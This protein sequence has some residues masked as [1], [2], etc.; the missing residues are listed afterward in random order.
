LNKIAVIALGSN[1]GD[2]HAHLTYAVERLAELL[3]GVRVSST[4]ESAPAAPATLQDPHYLNA[5]AIGTTS[6]S[7]R[8]LLASLLEIERL[9][10]RSRPYPGAPRTLDLDLVLLGD[11]IVKEPG[12]EVPHPRFR[13]R[14]FV[15]EPLVELAPD[16][17]DPMTGLTIRALLE[18]LRP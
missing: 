10:G 18:R 15:L 9:C 2:R 1:Q 5:V 17:V 6:L 12:V 14:R 16:L 3:D 13:E 7:A 8:A 11:E 4:I